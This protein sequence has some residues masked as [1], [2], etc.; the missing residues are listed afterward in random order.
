MVPKEQREKS[1]T[2]KFSE[3]DYKNMAKFCI[4]AGIKHQDFL[5]FSMLYCLNNKIYPKQF[6]IIK[7]IK[8]LQQEMQIK[9]ENLLS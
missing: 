8:K 3:L 1:L 4:D 6:T 2:V 9:K 7:N 5:C